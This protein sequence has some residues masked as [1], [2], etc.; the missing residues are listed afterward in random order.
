MRQTDSQSLCK[1][2]CSFSVGQD[3]LVA[4]IQHIQGFGININREHG[5]LISD[6]FSWTL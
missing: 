2:D 5:R 3:M 6:H 1:T 4:H